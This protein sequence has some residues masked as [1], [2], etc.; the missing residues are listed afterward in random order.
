MIVLRAAVMVTD[1]WRIREAHQLLVRAE[2]LFVRRA[3]PAGGLH[4]GCTGS[5]EMGSRRL[6]ADLTLKGDPHP[7]KAKSIG[8]AGHAH[9]LTSTGGL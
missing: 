2:L 5:P 1:T 4:S 3:P 8:A 7:S 9:T 6:D